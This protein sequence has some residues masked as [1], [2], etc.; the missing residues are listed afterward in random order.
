MKRRNV[1]ITGISGAVAALCLALIGY[2]FLSSDKDTDMPVNSIIKDRDITFKDM[3]TYFKG[4]QFNSGDEDPEKYFSETVINTDTIKY[5][6]FLQREIEAETLED[7]LKA[8]DMYLHSI[9]EKEKADE[10]FALYR[11]FCMYEV[12]LAEMVREWP[13]PE[14]ADDMI[15]YLKEIQE[16]RRD[17]FGVETADAI[18]GIE[19]KGQ[20]YRIRK[21]SIVHDPNL[22]G[23]EKDSLI[24]DLKAQMWG[25]GPD[26][27]EDPPQE[28]YEKYEKYQENKA[29]YKRDLDE[30]S[31]DQR[32]EMIAEFRNSVFTPEQIARLEMVD[33]ELEQEKTKEDEYYSREY[34]IRMDQSM[35]I[36]EQEAAIRELQDQI[37]GDDAESF[38]RIQN[39]EKALEDYEYD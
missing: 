4:N 30:L 9:M 33:D 10:M 15:R 25:T 16:Y 29:L 22:Y 3:N 2:H 6:K 8:V 34:S 14:D 18:W 32:K 35:S 20:E 7:H 12:D 28:D 13:P 27:I 5:F 26:T 36:D 38:R 21:G 23:A 31:E 39:I 19:V 37:F 24:S 17:I 1:I 11:K